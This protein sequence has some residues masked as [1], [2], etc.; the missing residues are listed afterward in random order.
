M[1]RLGLGP[2][3]QAP[4]SLT[5]GFPGQARGQLLVAVSLCD[6]SVAL[7]TAVTSCASANGFGSIT[8]PG[9][10]L[11]VRSWELPPLT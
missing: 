3:A 2:G 6:P 7:E 5:W 10:P 9:T 11:E 1:Q 4:C 8:L